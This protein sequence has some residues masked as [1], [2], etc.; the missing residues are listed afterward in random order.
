MT[1]WTAVLGFSVNCAGRTQTILGGLQIRR[2]AQTN[3]AAASARSRIL[4]LTSCSGT[5]AQY[6]CAGGSQGSNL[7]VVIAIMAL[8]T[9]RITASTDG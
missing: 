9:H 6:R 2:S 1:S 8:D 7:P 5:L 4:L 3:E